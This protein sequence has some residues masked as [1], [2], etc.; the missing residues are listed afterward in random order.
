MS[1]TTRTTE[2]LRDMLFEELDKF[3]SGKLDKDHVDA[4]TKI[5]NTIMK[6]VV[7]DLEAAK[8]LKDFNAGKDTPQAIADLNLNIMLTTKRPD[9]GVL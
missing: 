3:K 7:V 9:D 1:K 5:S 2:G 6:T 8:L 4:V